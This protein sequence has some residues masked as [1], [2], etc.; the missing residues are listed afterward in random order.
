MLNGTQTSLPIL[1]V[2]LK[3][4]L[5]WYRF[6]IRTINVD[7]KP[8]IP[9]AFHWDRVYGWEA[10][11]HF[12]DRDPHV[13]LSQKVWTVAYRIPFSGEGS[14][15]GEGTREQIHVVPSMQFHFFLVSSP[16]RTKGFSE[17][18]IFSLFLRSFSESL[19]SECN[20]TSVLTPWSPF[21]SLT[22]AIVA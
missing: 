11:F 17:V 15:T 14:P 22:W 6:C 3:P 18:W 4:E 12:N 16:F 2:S 7:L 10:V 13:H 8:I 1:L 21:C 19:F 5:S 20:L 9:L